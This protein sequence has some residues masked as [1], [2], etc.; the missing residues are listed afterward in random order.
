VN[1][2]KFTP[3]RTQT[4]ASF[5][6][7][8]IRRLRERWEK[9]NEG[10]EWNPEDE[11]AVSPMFRSVGID[12]VIEALRAH[13]DADAASFI[14][15]YDECS[16]TDRK[17]LPVEFIA[18]SSGIGSVRLLEIAQ[19]ALFLY[20]KMQTDM[21][22]AAHI[23]AVVAQSLKMAKTPKGLHDREMM[24]KASKILPIPK[25]A[26]IGVW[27]NESGEKEEAPEKTTP[28]WRTA[29]DRLREINDATDPKRLPSPSATPI[30]IGGHIDRMQSETVEILRGE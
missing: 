25:G 30:N 10:E 17:H 11:P 26:Q 4:A 6:K 12:R 27:L 23:P 3:K 16:V 7:D 5:R 24:L 18:F 14:A 2:K 22:M 8:A 19:S 15:A 28:L 9:E 20:G 29:E 21:L 1:D 13:D